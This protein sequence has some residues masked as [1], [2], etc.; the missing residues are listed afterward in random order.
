M[1]NTKLDKRFFESTRGKIVL[2][3]RNS[4][5]TVNDL[6]E[7]LG[8]SDNAV[9]AHLSVLERDGMV[10]QSGAVK[11]YRKPHFTYSLTEESYKL[12]PKSYDSLLNRLL[13]Q[14]KLRMSTAALK[15]ILS[16]LGKSL[17]IS[18]EAPI[19][20]TE[21]ERLNNALAALAEVGG[22]AVIEHEEGRVIIRSESCPFGNTVKEHPEMCKAAESML[23][24]IVGSE[25]TE[26]C[27]R[28]DLPKCRF[29]VAAK[30]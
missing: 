29:E 27:D 15:E 19:S 4:Q 22:S 3:L 20:A 13:D 23:S 24:E 9:R 7:F 5:R 10:S 28:T 26:N 2:Q 30:E 12:F 6:A 18:E 1:S 17:G 25:V 16:D 14:L 21:D 8:I 11:G